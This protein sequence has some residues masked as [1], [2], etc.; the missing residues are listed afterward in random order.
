MRDE[1]RRHLGK[2]VLVQLDDDQAVG[3][4]LERVTAVTLALSDP[5]VVSSD[6]K[7]TSADGEIVVSRHSIIWIQ[8]AT[9]G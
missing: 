8:V 2:P 9:D 4:V 7:Q 6:G 1:F 3:G 5:Y